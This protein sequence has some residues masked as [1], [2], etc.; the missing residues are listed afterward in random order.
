MGL[1]AAEMLART[2]K[3]PGEIYGALT[4]QFGRAGLRAHR[5]A[6][7]PGA[8]GHIGAALARTSEHKSF[9]LRFRAS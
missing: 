2:G 6:R 7:H 1:L 5:R 9:R 3:D 4:G 8:E